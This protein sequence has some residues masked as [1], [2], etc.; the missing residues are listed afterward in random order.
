MSEYTYIDAARNVRD[1]VKSLNEAIGDAFKY[2][3]ETEIDTIQEFTHA[4][5]L[6]YV[7][8]ETRKILR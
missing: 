1:A 3:V 7:S 4:G 8:A 6:T 2:G 5:Y